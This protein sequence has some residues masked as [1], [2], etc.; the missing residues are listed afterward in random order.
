LDDKLLASGSADTTVL[1]WDIATAL[2]QYAA[3]PPK[4]LA[5]KELE[6]LC[7]DLAAEDGD[8]ALRA[9][10]TLVADKDS[11][12]AVVKDR[13]LAIQKARAPERVA[14]WIARLGVLKY[15]EREEAVREL[16]KL[17]PDA[18]PALV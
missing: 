9:V 2:R 15:A 3:A 4:P 8:V 7:D 14:A 16:R 1:L 5:P 13:L 10:W 17:G 6:R 11:S 18:L 12:V